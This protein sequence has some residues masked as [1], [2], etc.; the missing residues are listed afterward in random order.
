MRTH[1]TAPF[2]NTNKKTRLSA[3]YIGRGRWSRTT[4]NGVKVRCLTAW[5]YPHYGKWILSCKPYRFVKKKW[6]EWWGSNPRITEPQSAVLTTSPHPPHLVIQHLLY[7]GM[8]YTM[9]AHRRQYFKF[10]EKSSCTRWIP[11]TFSLSCPELYN[12]KSN[13]T[14]RRSYV[15]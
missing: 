10:P 13:K 7:N 4:D 12:K 2:K 3:Q 1:S 6:G 11:S 8:Y 14:C 15:S 9:L 5:L